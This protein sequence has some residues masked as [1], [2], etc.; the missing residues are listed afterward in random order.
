MTCGP[1]RPGAQARP[2]PATA[3][4]EPT[5]WPQPGQ[6]T[7]S[8]GT[9]RAQPGQVVPKRAPHCMQ[10]EASA[11]F[12]R[13]HS[14]HF[15]ILNCRAAA[16]ESGVRLPVPPFLEQ[17]RPEGVSNEPQLVALEDAYRP[18]RLIVRIG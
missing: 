11:G 18:L 12:S 7:A 13:P 14:G 1:S 8:L 10:N 3:G 2:A 17:I 15:T 5:R 16:Q 6:K 9:G 4:N